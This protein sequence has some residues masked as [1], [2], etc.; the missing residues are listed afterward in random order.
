MRDEKKKKILEQVGILRTGN[1]GLFFIDRS[2][3]IVGFR[4]AGL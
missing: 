1:C 4:K 3:I 2:L